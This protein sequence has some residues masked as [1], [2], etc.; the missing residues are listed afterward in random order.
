V[1][2]RA[3]SVDISISRI[4]ISTSS[5]GSLSKAPEDE[6]SGPCWVFAKSAVLPRTSDILSDIVKVTLE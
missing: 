5:R 4:I 1:V 6:V 2:R 3:Q